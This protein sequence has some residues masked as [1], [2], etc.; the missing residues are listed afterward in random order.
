MTEQT[1]GFSHRIIKPERRA[2]QLLCTQ[3]IHL[4]SA[5]FHWLIPNQAVAW[6]ID[7]VDMQINFLYLIQQIIT[8]KRMEKSGWWIN[9]EQNG[10]KESTRCS[11]RAWRCHW[12]KKAKIDT[13]V[14]STLP[15][16][17]LISERCMQTLH[18]FFKSCFNMISQI[19]EHVEHVLHTM[20]FII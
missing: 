15:K 10:G 2:S 6:N 18:F 8:S 19:T 5:Q 11:G 12:L 14:A 4:K 9:H 13:W 16:L 3:W 20:Y 17:N 1:F 7:A